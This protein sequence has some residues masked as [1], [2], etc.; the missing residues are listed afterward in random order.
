MVISSERKRFLDEICN[1]W[2]GDPCYDLCDVNYDVI[3]FGEAITM[4]ENRLKELKD[5]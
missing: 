2:V 5:R 4:L 1:E 3:K